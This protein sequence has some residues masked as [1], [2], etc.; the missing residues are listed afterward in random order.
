MALELDTPQVANLKIL[1]YGEGGLGK[2]SLALT[3]ENPVLL[4]FND[5]SDVR[6]SMPI[7]ALINLYSDT[8]YKNW[9][10]ALRSASDPEL[11]RFN[12][13]IIDTY[14]DLLEC[15]LD[16]LYEKNRRFFVARGRPTDSGWGEIKRLSRDYMKTISQWRKDIVVIA[17]SNNVRKNRNDEYK[18]YPDI[19]GSSKKI[20]E[21]DFHLIGHLTINDNQRELSFDHTENA[22][23]K[24][25]IELPTYKLPSDQ[26]PE[27]ATFLQEVITD[28]KIKLRER[29]TRNRLPHEE[30]SE[31]NRLIGTA[32]QPHEFDTILDKIKSIQGAAH[33]VKMLKQNL[34]KRTSSLGIKY[35]DQLPG[36]EEVDPDYEAQLKKDSAKEKSLKAA[37]TVSSK[38]KAE[39]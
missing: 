25:C 27:F 22:M 12:T 29:L 20:F 8:P 2:T 26:S 17:H 28:V 31:I 37:E 21:R 35:N 19:L 9:E 15:L 4:T 34:R 36:F 6:A 18:S 3:S 16:Y 33:V 1:I 13:Q 32:D 30:S 11:A 7:S 14:G 23:G 5:Q 24:N 39:K 10:K 38:L